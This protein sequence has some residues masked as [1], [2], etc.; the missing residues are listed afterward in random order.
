HYSDDSFERAV[1][2]AAS[3]VRL[4]AGRGELVRLITTSGHDTGFV[5][6][7]HEVE[8]AID[9]LA[10]VSMS[11]SGTLTGTLRALVHRRGGGG[12]VTCTGPLGETERSVLASMGTRFAVHLA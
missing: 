4:C 6:G 10:T 8:A 5:G 12:L 11:G 9:L 3:V 2:A 1:S 7:E